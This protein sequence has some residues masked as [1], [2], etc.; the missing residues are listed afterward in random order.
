MYGVTATIAQPVISSVEKG[1][2]GRGVRRAGRGH[3]DRNF[4]S[5]PSFK[6]DQNH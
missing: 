4:S 6:Q 2:S 5:A 3:M 1:I